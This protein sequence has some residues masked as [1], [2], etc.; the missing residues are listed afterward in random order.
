MTE[1]FFLNFKL[2][3]LDLNVISVSFNPQGRTEPGSVIIN[4]GK[5]YC[6]KDTMNTEA[7][8]NQMQLTITGF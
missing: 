6:W 4:T 7:K 5:S 1:A 3:D 2:T 8:D